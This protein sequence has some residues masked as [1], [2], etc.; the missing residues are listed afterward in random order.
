MR[1]IVVPIDFDRDHPT[2]AN[3]RAW[4]IKDLKTGF[5][6]F[7]SYKTQEIAQEIADRKNQKED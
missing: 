6:N 1:F 4:K 3:E 7:S 2:N 5:V